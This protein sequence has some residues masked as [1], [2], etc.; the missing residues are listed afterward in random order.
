MS[1]LNPSTKS[2]AFLTG[3][4]SLIDIR[5][6]STYRRMQK[7]TPSTPVRDF[8]AVARSTGQQFR[9][10]FPAP[11]TSEDLRGQASEG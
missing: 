2:R 4:G 6:D 5:G 7:L 3:F 9:Q 10:N 8:P 11:E 1:I